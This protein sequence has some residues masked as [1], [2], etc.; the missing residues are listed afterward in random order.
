APLPVHD[1]A[2]EVGYGGGE[3]LLAQAL[4]APSTGF[5][6][7]EYFINGVAK[8]C[9]QIKAHDVQNVRLY[10]GD[11]KTLFLAL[12]EASLGAIYILFPDPWPKTRH[13]KRRFI[14]DW[15]L[16][17]MA[18]LLRPGGQLRVASDIPGYISWTL[19]AIRRHSAFRWTARRPADW[20]Q[21]PGDWP[22]TRYEAKAL[23]EGRK[24]IYLEFHRERDKAR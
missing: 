3:H 7:C 1:L 6:G 23:T 8:S 21:R 2:L 13:H 11:A 15:T 16:R 18:R 22:A 12:P 10:G 14:S 4:M 19:G 24:P 5:I 9:T 17:E 20:S